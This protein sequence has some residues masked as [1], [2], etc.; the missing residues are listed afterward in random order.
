M[1]YVDYRVAW[2]LERMVRSAAL[3]KYIDYP[4][5]E[6]PSRFSPY[7]T[8]LDSYGTEDSNNNLMSTF[9]SI[10][11]DTEDSVTPP[12]YILRRLLSPQMSVLD[13]CGVLP[14]LK[15]CGS[16]K[17]EAADPWLDNL[18]PRFF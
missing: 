13:V 16:E 15:C 9:S 2:L 10:A 14:S 17:Y 12:P 5:S 18:Y 7:E 11:I 3:C 6:G 4:A 8:Q 1:V